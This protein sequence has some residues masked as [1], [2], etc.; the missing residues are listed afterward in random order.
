MRSTNR[1]FRAD[2]DAVLHMRSVNHVSGTD[3]VVTVQLRF[4]TGTIIVIFGS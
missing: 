2:A 4:G 3:N 1:V